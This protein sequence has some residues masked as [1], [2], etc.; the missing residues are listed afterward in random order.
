MTK[1]VHDAYIHEDTNETGGPLQFACEA[2]HN[3]MCKGTY[4]TPNTKTDSVGL[5]RVD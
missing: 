3:T 2:L 5:V 4:E 1:C